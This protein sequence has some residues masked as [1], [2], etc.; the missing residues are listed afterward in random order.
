[1]SNR[2]FQNNLNAIGTSSNVFMF[3]FL[4]SKSCHRCIKS[5]Q[6]LNVAHRFAV[7]LFT[8]FVTNNTAPVGR[9]ARP[10]I[11]CPV[12]S[13]LTRPLCSTF[14]Y[15]CDLSSMTTFAREEVTAGGWKYFVYLPISQT[16][17]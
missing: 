13:K 5:C 3:I 15:F 14:D 4:D 9:T 1:M 12:D 8:V 10:A 2:K 7:L 6:P 17:V 11:N 16:R